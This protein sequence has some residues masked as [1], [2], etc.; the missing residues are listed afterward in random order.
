MTVRERRCPSQM[1]AGAPGPRWI[2][3]RPGPAQIDPGPLSITGYF[4][5]QLFLCQTGEMKGGSDN[6]KSY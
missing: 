3:D 1:D 4:S 2:R 5:L 6:E